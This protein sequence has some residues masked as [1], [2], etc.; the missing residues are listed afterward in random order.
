M[1]ILL[2]VHTE[3]GFY[4]DLSSLIRTNTA[5]LFDNQHAM[6]DFRKGV[7]GVGTG[8]K[9]TKTYKQNTV[10]YIHYIIHA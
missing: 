9:I 8:G 6:D 3:P 7:G 2:K 5:G 4:K 1:F 10:I